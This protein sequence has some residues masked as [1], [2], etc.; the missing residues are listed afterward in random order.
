MK[1]IKIFVILLFSILIISGCSCTSSMCSQEDLNN[2]RINIE[3]KYKND[4][5]YKIKLREEAIAKD[6]TSEEDIEK[7][8]NQKIEK[9]IEDEYNNHPKACL[10]TENMDD[11]DSGANISAKS[12]KGAFKEGLLE[13]LIVFPISWLLITFTNLFGGGGGAKI[14]SII[15]T[16]LIIR[17]L[18]LLLTFKSQV[19]TQRLQSIQG[20][21]SEISNKLKDPNL[22][23]SEKS[24]LSM[25]LMEI[26]KKNNINP[27]ASLIPTFVSLPIF[28]SVWSAVSQTLVIRTGTFVGIELGAT[29][30]SQ[31]FGLNVGAI[32]LFLLMAGTQILSMKMPN[33][34]RNKTA[35]YK[36]KKQ[37]EEANKQMSMMSNVM[38]IMILI[39]GFVLPSA[40]AVYWTVG[41][42]F[43]II[44]T[45][46]FQNPKIKDKLSMIG[47]RKKKAKVVE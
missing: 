20:E 26:Y 1:K 47:N 16:T 11:P 45:I 46:I 31:V 32:V 40:L 21:V 18:M 8:V 15:V 38:I 41:A 34:I 7:Y 14:L 44:Q 35:N 22:S 17:I 42:V 10:T 39:T 28:L 3:N 23:Q 12:W 30:S 2:I 36:N 19:Q 6:I 25:K 13:G 9:K 43:S 27:I 5:E 4:E 24:R 37:I 33:I 29:V